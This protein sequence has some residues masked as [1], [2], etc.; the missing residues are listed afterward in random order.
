MWN[1]R[2]KN[3]YANVQKNYFLIGRNENRVAFAHSI[4]SVR[5]WKKSYIHLGDYVTL[6]QAWIWECKI[7]QLDSIL[8]CGDTAM[9]PVAKLPKEYK[10]IT[11]TEVN[12][13]DS[14]YVTGSKIIQNGNYY[15]LNPVLIHRKR[16]HL[17]CTATGW[18]VIKIGRRAE[19]HD[20]AKPT[21]D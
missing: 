19:T 21:I 11:E 4:P 13:I 5:R 1:K 16:Q 10:T 18:H 8:R 14:H 12:L 15:V 20:F 3:G 9:F 7:N 17:D 6:A 2:Y